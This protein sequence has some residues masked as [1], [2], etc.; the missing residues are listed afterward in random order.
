MQ[1]ETQRDQTSF[2]PVEV[3]TAADLDA[4]AGGLAMSSAMAAS[5]A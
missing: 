1:I 2:F 4:V 3:L 5:A